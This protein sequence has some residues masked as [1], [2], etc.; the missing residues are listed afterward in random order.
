MEPYSYEKARIVVRE[1]VDL[2][3]LDLVEKKVVTDQ[4]VLDIVYDR[5]SLSD[6]EIRKRY[7]GEI[8]RDFYGREVPK[9]VHG[10]INLGRYTSSTKLMTEAILKLY[11]EIANPILLVRKLNITTNHIIYEKNIPKQDEFEQLDLF[12]DYEQ[13]ARERELEERELQREK[14]AQKAVLEMKKKFGK[15][16]V[17]K[18]TDLQEGATTISRNQQI[19]GHKA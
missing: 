11:D 13:I 6:P 14:Q 1:M 10:S 3:S 17:F 16:A 15:N 12:T 18:G 7:H 19:G 8:V 4:L 2:V 5:T 9:S